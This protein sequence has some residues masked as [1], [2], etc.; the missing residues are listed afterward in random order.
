M[1]KL[2]S[3]TVTS[4][5]PESPA[6]MAGISKG[7]RIISVNGHLIND[8]IDLTFYSQEPSLTIKMR[9]GS[10]IFRTSV[11]KDEYKGMGISLNPMKIRTCRNNC[12]F[13]FVS[14]LPK[15][16][17]RSLYIKD[18]D[19]RF[20]FLYGNYVTLGNITDDDRKRIIEQKLSPLYISVH[21]TNHE[22]RRSMIGNKKAPD[23]LSELKYMKAKKIK[24]HTQIVLCPGH[25]D[26]KEL[27]KTINDLGKLYPYAISMAVV[28]VGLTRHREKSLNPVEKQD[29]LDAIAIVEKFQKRFMKKHGDPIVY[30][31][32]E[33]F[34]KSGLPFPPARFYGDFPQI[35][36]GVGMVPSFIHKSRF[37]RFSSHK[38]SKK[39]FIAF[40]GMSFYPYLS[41]FIGK[42]R[43]KTG[44]KIKLVPVNNDFFGRSV[45]V[46]GL[47]TG[48]DII[49]SLSDN[50]D[51]SDIILIPDV[52]LKDTN[53]VLLDDSSVSDIYEALDREVR[54][55]ESTP[56][57]L[58]KGLED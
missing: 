38:L 50:I 9:R 20:S 5:L 21:T 23:I 13:C 34:I 29:A 33:L 4:V 17:R 44:V 42:L 15:G 30:G 32:D 18:E 31:S 25:N 36:N 10:K 43:E 37:L 49:K 26:K 55:I 11:Q 27:E 53:E 54:V 1:N 58:L 40:T 35:E 3:N 6:A 45:T 2:I 7:D 41:Q 8:D 12:I 16:L 22:L 46:T 39:R 51:N 28:P 56:A 52:V 47:L 57:G 14:Q 19:Y 24:F 48:R